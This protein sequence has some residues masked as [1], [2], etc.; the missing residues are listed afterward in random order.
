MWSPIRYGMTYNDYSTSLLV[1]VCMRAL[2]MIIMAHSGSVTP[3]EI[4][5][6]KNGYKRKKVKKTKPNLGFYI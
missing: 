2:N 5:I 4:L 3:S 6:L 1:H